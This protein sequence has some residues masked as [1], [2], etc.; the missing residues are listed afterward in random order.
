M[1]VFCGIL[2]FL[3]TAAAVPLC[4][5]LMDGVRA[6]DMSNAIVLG[7]LLAVVYTVLRPLLRLLLKVVNF[8]TLGLLYVAVDAWLVWTAAALVENSVQFQNFWWALAV[9]AVVNAARLVIDA[10][11]GD[12]RRYGVKQCIFY[13]SMTTGSARWALWP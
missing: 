8:C 3:V 6:V 1:G 4:A 7:L 11:S 13:W 10:F 12:V 5:Q 9:A 2:R